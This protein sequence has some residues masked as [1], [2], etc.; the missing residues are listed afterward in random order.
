MSSY[1]K[2]AAQWYKNNPPK[3]YQE[4]E[5]D[6]KNMVTQTL[7]EANGEYYLDPNKPEFNELFKKW[8]IYNYSSS[9]TIDDYEQAFKRQI[10]AFKNDKTRFFEKNIKKFDN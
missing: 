1:E 4:I 9:I 3:T 2:T 7:Y 10:V 8:P 6:V 5:R